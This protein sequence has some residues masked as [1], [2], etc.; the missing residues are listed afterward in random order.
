[1]TGIFTANS[2]LG[3]DVNLILQIVMLLLLIIGLFYKKK[4]KF[5]MHGVLMLIAVILH[6]LTF[7]V[8]MGPPFYESFNYYITATSD[9]SV[10]TTLAHAVPGAIAMIMGIIL[11]VAWAIRPSN[12]ARCSRLK[13]LM[14]VTLLLW[15]I[16]LLFGIATYFVF[17]V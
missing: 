16:S 15:L 12:V 3:A 4:R 13:R 1:M 6:V 17:Y 7:L 2:H 5:K 11:V 10:Q 8:V 14:D 9:L